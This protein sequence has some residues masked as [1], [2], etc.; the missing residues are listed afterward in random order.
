MQNL[1]NQV[2]HH[3]GP[4]WQ[5]EM[6]HD[7]AGYLIASDGRKI[8]VYHDQ[9]ANRLEVS[10]SYPRDD[11]NTQ[12]ISAYD[13]PPKITVNAGRDPRAIAL[14]ISRRFLP[15]FNAMWQEALK[16]EAEHIAYAANQ[17]ANVQRLVEAWSPGSEP[18]RD[19]SEIHVGGIASTGWYG[20]IA[21][22]ADTA[23]LTLHNLS[24]DAAIEIAGIVHR[25]G[26]ESK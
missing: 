25:Y 3:M 5:A 20:S 6:N 8:L 9:H 14:D 7:R 16:R 21:V 1:L 12:Y 4:S 18:R 19:G 10:G 22:S 24:I 11:R 17:K 13:N 2:A 23:T 26:K 15:A